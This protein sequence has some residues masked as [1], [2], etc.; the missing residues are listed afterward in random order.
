MASPNDNRL[1]VVLVTLL[2]GVIARDEQEERWQDL[3]SLE[4]AVRDHAAV[5]GLELVVVQDEG[6]AFLR[7]RE[8]DSDSDGDE[9]PIPRLINRRALSYPV[10]LVL[11]ILRRKLAEH[12][13]SSGELRLV[14]ETEEMVDAVRTFLPAGKTE[15]RMTDQITSHLRKVADLGFIRFL[16]NDPGKFEVRRILKAFIDAQWLLELEQ[17]LREYAEGSV[18]GV[19]EDGATNEDDE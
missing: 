2:R 18:A 15:A 7:Q 19:N 16:G 5:L 3:L 9:T 11:A 13:A 1:S 8:S 17:Q 12:D 4:H 10:S 14:I 6:Y